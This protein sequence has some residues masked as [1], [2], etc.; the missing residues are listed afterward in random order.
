MSIQFNNPTFAPSFLNF[1]FDEDDLPMEDVPSL[2]GSNWL[3]KEGIGDIVIEDDDFYF[4][5]TEFGNGDEVIG[6]SELAIG[7]RKHYE[8]PIVIQGWHRS[9]FL[10]HLWE[11]ASEGVERGDEYNPIVYYV[12]A[13]LYRMG[14]KEKGI[15]N[16]VRDAEFRSLVDEVANQVEER[17]GWLFWDHDK[18]VTPFSM[19][20]PGSIA[21]VL[22]GI[23]VFVDCYPVEGAVNPRNSYIL[24]KGHEDYNP[25]DIVEVPKADK[26]DFDS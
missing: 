20:Y 8:A 11:C 4:E 16:L 26:E 10:Y 7:R 13:A 24:H 18:P 21:S 17:C 3:Q 12:E 14:L 15:H 5:G 19:V 6:K 25:G 23:Q 2:I 9:T 1:G 22:E